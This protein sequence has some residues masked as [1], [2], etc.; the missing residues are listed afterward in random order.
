MIA[1]VVLVILGGWLV[2]SLVTTAVCAALVRGGQ[3]EDRALGY[4]E[5]RERPH[6]VRT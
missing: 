1:T 5:E 2:L 3:G 4:V 6:V